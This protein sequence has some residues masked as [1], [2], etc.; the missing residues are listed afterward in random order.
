[1]SNV[2]DEPPLSLDGLQPS[3]IPAGRIVVTDPAALARIRA[4]NARK[5]EEDGL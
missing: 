5:R 4:M 1:M 3:D 2:E